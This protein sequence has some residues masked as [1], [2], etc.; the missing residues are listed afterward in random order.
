MEFG[1]HLPIDVGYTGAPMT[2]RQLLDYAL[3]R[4]PE[5]TVRFYGLVELV[6]QKAVGDADSVDAAGLRREILRCDKSARHRNGGVARTGR[7]CGGFRLID[8]GRREQRKQGQ[9]GP[10]GAL[11]YHSVFV[12][13]RWLVGP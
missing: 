12:P 6:H 1:A 5:Q 2:A 9:K 4:G 11:S 10:E 8:A 3:P 7:G 13:T